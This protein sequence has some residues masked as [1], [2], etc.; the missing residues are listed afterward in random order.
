MLYISYFGKLINS[1]LAMNC[2]CNQNIIHGILACEDVR[3]SFLC[4]GCEVRVIC[5]KFS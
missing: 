1:Y 4:Y 2:L 5:N 3:Y